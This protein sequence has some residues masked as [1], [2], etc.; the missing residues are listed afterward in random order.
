MKSKLQTLAAAVAMSFSSFSF[1]VQPAGVANPPPFRAGDSAA[2]SNSNSA[3]NA[4]SNSA[5]NAAAVSGSASHSN[6]TSNSIG[7]NSSTNA[8]TVNT[9]VTNNVAPYQ[10][11]IATPTSTSNNTQGDTVVTNNTSLTNS[12]NVPRQPVATAFAAPLTSG[13]DTCMGSSSVGAQGVGFGISV[14]STWVDENCKRLKNSRELRSMGFSN[15]AVALLCQD[16]SVADAMRT[17]GTAC[18]TPVVAKPVAVE[19][20]F[21]ESM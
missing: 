16:A 5:A 12:T 13:I 1:G 11:T 9:G 2:V 19:F 3:A 21:P 15:A 20:K 8:N 7:I 18:P 17:A 4:A 14:G 10:T 6:S